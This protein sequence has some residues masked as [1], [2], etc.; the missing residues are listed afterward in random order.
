MKRA[1]GILFL[2]GVLGLLLI[3][4]VP[5]GRDHTNPRVIAEPT[6]DSAKT[7]ATAVIACFDCHSNETK[8]PWYSNIAPMSWLVQRDVDEGR[9]HMNLSEWTPGQGSEAAEKVHRSLHA[10]GGLE[11]PREFVF[12]DRAAIGLGSVFLH[13]KAEVNWYQLF[14]DLVRDFDVDA[15]EK[16]QTNLLNRHG[17]PLPV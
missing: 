4:L 12:M 11:I 15:L 6:W 8:W 16:R 17:V 14:H 9:E 10:V 1:I 3:Q 2:V 13:L 5:Y 7:R